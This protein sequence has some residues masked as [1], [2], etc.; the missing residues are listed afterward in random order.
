MIDL[1]VTR[2]ILAAM[3][4]ITSAGIVRVGFLP[5]D[6]PQPVAATPAL[7]HELEQMGWS[8]TKTLQPKTGRDV[9]T[10]QG[11]VFRLKG[12]NPPI[13]LTLIPTRAR[14]A[15]TLGVAKILEENGTGTTDRAAKTIWRGKDAL[16]ITNADKGLLSA[17]TCVVPGGAAPHAGRLVNLRLKHDPP[18]TNLDR[19]KMLAGL[20][21]PRE[22]GCLFAEFRTKDTKSAQA[23][24]LGAWDAIKTTLKHEA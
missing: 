17:S 11:Q 24:L 13:Q 12:S 8:L 4:C 18:N 23:E 15:G 7:Q 3:T 1:S 5:M 6:A 20:K 16:L 19:L 14:G 21:Q 22:W 9:S 2:L 10:A